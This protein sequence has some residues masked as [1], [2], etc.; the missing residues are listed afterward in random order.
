MES[1]SRDLNLTFRAYRPTDEAACLDIFTSNIPEYFSEEEREDFIDFLHR[2]PGRYGV[3]VDAEERVVACGGVAASRSDPRGADLTWGMVHHR[4]HK[5]GV[6]R[7]LT[8]GR[9]DWVNEMPDVA[10]VYLNTAH[11][12]EGF[13]E[14]F[15]FRTVKR[16]LNGYR[17]GLH[18]CD[19]EWHKTVS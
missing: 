13:Y 6:G 9:L 15:G 1:S 8:Q 3:V 16:I 10:V 18:R 7:A 11:L 19:M 12:T 2:L 5:H 4:L 14:K 17:E